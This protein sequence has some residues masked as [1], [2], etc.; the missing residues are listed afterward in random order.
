MPSLVQIKACPPFGAKTLSESKL[1]HCLWDP[2][3]TTSVK[4]ESKY[5]N[6]HSRKLIWKCYM[7][8]GNHLSWPQCVKSNI[9]LSIYITKQ[10][11]NIYQCISCNTLYAPDCCLNTI[12]RGTS[13]YW[14]KQYCKISSYLAKSLALN[15][16]KLLSGVWQ[17]FCQ[18]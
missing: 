8:S 4:F 14:Y 2:Y 10:H 7:Q 3:E 11:Y 9:K 15:A 17:L 1:T 6:F 16:N 12:G 13:L 5:N 18:S